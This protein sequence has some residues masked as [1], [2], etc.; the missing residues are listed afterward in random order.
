ML[1]KHLI[2]HAEELDEHGYRVVLRGD[3]DHA[4]NREFHE[5]GALAVPWLEEI[6]RHAFRAKLRS[7]GFTLAPDAKVLDACCGFGYLG[8]FIATEHGANIVFCDLSQHQLSELRKRLPQSLSRWVLASD[9]T[10]LPYG[11]AVFD[12]VVGNSFLHHL[13][14][15]PSALSEFHRV[16]KKGGRL[17]LLHEPATSANFWE[18]FP[19]S[20]LK[21]TSPTTVFTDLWMF[22]RDDL[23]RLTMEAGFAHA[24]V[25]GTG[26]I[27]SVILNWL[28]I[29]GVKL[30]WQR[31]F[32]LSSAYELRTWLNR[33]EAR[34]PR[35]LKKWSP[36]SLMLTA[37]KAAE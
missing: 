5:S 18:S 15:V 20:L 27:S 19:I 35:A 14:D 24:D 31:Q 2:P 23:Q 29:L 33:F 37:R 11:D 28:L 16:L 6:Y 17:V 26:T 13:P 4:A 1:Q 32:P 22:K 25:V 21:D 36:P 30:N 8:S 34:V 7:A 12:A 10:R 3:I 9:V